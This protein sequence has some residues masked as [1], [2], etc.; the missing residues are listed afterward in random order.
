[1]TYVLNAE[2][3]ALIRKLVPRSNMESR[4]RR[5][6]QS[7][8]E[9]PF[10][11]NDHGEGSYRHSSAG[12]NRSRLYHRAM[13]F[14]LV[15]CCLCV[16]VMQWYS[17]QAAQA[18]LAGTAAETGAGAAA[19]R[20]PGPNNGWMKHLRHIENKEAPKVTY[21]ASAE[22]KLYSFAPPKTETLSA[23]AKRRAPYDPSTH[24]ADQKKVVDMVKWAWKAY[25]TYAYG[26]D[27]LNVRDMTGMRTQEH[28]AALTLVDSLDTLFLV[29][30]FEE[31]DK[32][33]EWVKANLKDRMYQPGYISVFETTIRVL[34][35]LLSAFYL[36]GTDALLLL[37]LLSIASPQQDSRCCCF[38]V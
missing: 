7:V 29:G 2:V 25:D 10:F 33:S 13:Q 11:R 27:A 20:V 21:N 26:H 34:G 24:S 28:D 15:G 1:M 6:N 14:V 16:L 5:L 3:A 22:E 19:E 37:P 31:F 23:D 38:V 9:L 17:G 4:V 35:G 12:P 18:A 32:A 30:M 36:S 8:P